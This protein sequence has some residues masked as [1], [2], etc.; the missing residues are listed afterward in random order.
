MNLLKV[1]FGSAMEDTDFFESTNPLTTSFFEDA[2]ESWR[3]PSE[4]MAVVK[5]EIAP[6]QLG[7]VKF[8]GVRWRACCDRP[9]AIPAG[10]EVRVIGRRS[11]ILVVEP[12]E[13]CLLT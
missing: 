11:N 2:S 12:V 5:A 13:V 7:R 4:F 9:F 10:I 3:E 1:L 8:Q 6:G